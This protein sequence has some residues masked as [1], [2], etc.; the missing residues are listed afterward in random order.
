[1]KSIPLWPVVFLFTVAA[2]ANPFAYLDE[3]DPYYVGLDFPKLTTPQWV[4]EPDVDAVVILSIDDMRDSAKYEEYLRPTLN[5]L[6]AI[7]GRA[8]LSIMSCVVQPDD[9]QLQSWLD[10]GVHLGVHTVAHPCPILQK[11]NFDTAKE[12]YDSCVELLNNVPGNDA[13]AFRTPC[14]DSQNT[15]SPRF[16]AE[17]FNATTSS[18][19]YLDIDSSVFN[20]TT[21]NDPALPRSLVFEADGR[22]RFRKYLPFPAFTNTIE[23]YPYPYIIG[24]RCWE[25]PCTVPSDWEAQNLNEP[26]NDVSVADMKAA[27]DATV[28]K[29]GIYTLVFHPH[30]W[31]RNDQVVDLIDHAVD[32]YGPRVKFLNFREVLERIETNVLGGHSLR[33][34]QGGDNGVRLLDVNRDGFQDAVIGNASANV[35]RIWNPDAGKWTETSFPTALVNEDEHGNT[36]DAGVR[37]GSIDGQTVAV[38][39]NEVSAGAWRFADGAWQEMPALLI[40]FEART[41]ETGIDRGVRLRDLDRDG[42]CELLVLNDEQRAL[43]RWN[44]DNSSWQTQSASPPD[45]ARLVDAEGRDRGLRFVDI[46]EDH[47]DDIVVSSEEGYGIYL[48]DGVDNGWTTTALDATR[49]DGSEHESPLPPITVNGQNHGAWFHSRH[50]W[51]QNEGTDHL[52][53]LVDRR[54]YNDLLDDVTLQPKS[55]EASLTALH[56]RP[57][58]RA[59]LVAAEPLVIDPVAIAWGADGRLWVTE[60]RDYPMGMDGEG[61]PGSRVKILED[62]NGDG[63]YD[64]ATVF[65]DELGFATGVMPW[66]DGAL[67]TAAPLIFFAKDTDS[68]GQADVRETLFSGYGE[69]NQQHRVNGLRWGLDN[70]IYGANGDGGGDIRSEKTGDVESIRG[71]DFRIRPDEGLLDPQSGQ[72][73]FGRVRDDW[74]NWFGCANSLPMW[75]FAL[76][77][78]YMR[79]NP[80]FAPPNPREYFVPQLQVYPESR[81]LQRFNDFDHVNRTTSTCGVTVYRDTLLG[82]ALAANMFVCEPVHNLVHRAV[83]EPSGHTF[84]GRRAPGEEEAEFVAS[85]DNWFR[86]VMARTGPDGALWI[87]DMYRQVIEHPE[88]IPTEIQEQ[89]DTRAGD[90]RGRIYRIVPVDQPARAIPDLTA[91]NTNELVALLEGPNGTVRDM[92]HQRLVEQQDKSAVRP[93]KAMLA[94]HET[95]TA[96]LHALCILDGL[97][98]LDAKLIAGALSDSHPGVRRH[99]LRLS[100][101][102]LAK[103]KPVADAVLALQ[104]DPDAFVRMQ[105]IYTL[106]NWDDPRAAQ[107]LAAMAASEATDE[108]A[109]AAIMSSVNAQNLDAMID[110]MLQLARGEDTPTEAKTQIVPM[111]TAT[112]ATA[113]DTSALVTLALRITE[114]TLDGYAPWQLSLL[115]D[116]LSALRDQGLSQDAIA[117][118][119]GPT[120]ADLQP[121]F[122]QARLLAGNDGADTAL[123]VAAIRLVGG[124]PGRGD[125]DYAMLGA[126]INSTAP[127]EVVTAALDAL[128]GRPDERVPETL[129]ATWEGDSPEIHGRILDILLSRGEWLDALVAALEDGT[130]SLRQVDASRRQKLLNHTR[131]DI[132]ERALALF[133]DV[134][135]PD[136]QAIVEQYWPAIETR[137]EFLKGRGIFRERCASC[138]RLGEIGHAVGPDLSAISDRSPENILIS[139]L[140]PN[141]SVETRYL[142]YTV[143]TTDFLS[144]SGVLAAESG[145]SVTLLSPNG[146]RNTILRT[147]IENLKASDQS[148]MPNGLEDGLD[149]KAV[150]DLIAFVLD[151]RPEA[152]EFPGNE[153]RTVEPEKDGSI[154]LLASDAEIYGST[155]VFESAHNNL[156]YWGSEDDRAMWTVNVPSEGEYVVA[157]DY[158]CDSANGG[159]PFTIA[160]GEHV[161]SATAESTGTWDQYRNKSIGT[162]HLAAGTQ[163]ITVRPVG[164]PHDYLMDLRAITLTPVK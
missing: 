150:A 112:A 43:F 2:F 151:F 127:G 40:G 136:R 134:V 106:G 163:Q 76:D 142:D 46:D 21:P 4:G 147:E 8:A 35:T 56:V 83:V 86:P 152:K 17:I 55:P 27:I 16:F 137:G 41:A 39:R 28:I 156:G 109:T 36:Y 125:A 32:T 37:F 138:H 130:V 124:L 101:P 47:D 146:E 80:H 144:Y 57:G 89:I 102:Y 95:A 110:P 75:H 128:S 162:I 34:V 117:A 54:S 38:V 121:L 122:A 90:D 129:L 58:Y 104:N 157:V 5:R 23:D 161:A 113:E 100:E 62:E 77:D 159:N 68:D 10:E 119:G 60:M 108:Y 141:R 9:P 116:Y 87:V 164:D 14:C 63:I 12:T 78:G 94:D 140:D 61:Q 97:D 111:M 45:R 25:I 133:A 65:L 82:P 15:P 153:P 154:T 6:K 66:R 13:V 99:A 114:S 84:S 132:R 30:G 79:R 85:S 96:R 42:Q 160:C 91:L 64:T 148:P 67:I 70:W 88:Y 7:D 103:S 115:A 44:T 72:T 126:C 131:A 69:A 51:V 31:I 74:G 26:N 135:N 145:N 18:G 98:A 120:L 71:R 11:G 29:R 48:F 3:S 139:V 158:A 49:G 107:T 92:V 81:T 19:Q 33:N 118:E 24:G 50:L 59:E 123:R 53:D 52:P 93:L 1:M 105:L 143:E 20:I 155:L 149:V 73:Q 22:E